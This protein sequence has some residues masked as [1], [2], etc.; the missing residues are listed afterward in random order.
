VHV[1]EQTRKTDR[2]VVR[3]R[4]KLGA[5]VRDGREEVAAEAQL[6]LR[7]ALLAKRIRELADAMPPLSDER[8]ARL[9]GLL[10]GGA[11]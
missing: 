6:D 5:A 7:E 3:A 2:E 9:A 11:A 8:R 1:E 10:T 4:G